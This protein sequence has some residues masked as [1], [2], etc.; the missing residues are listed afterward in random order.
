MEG[1][2]SQPPRFRQPTF[3]GPR[4]GDS[5]FSNRSGSSQNDRFGFNFRPSMPGQGFAS[6]DGKK[7]RTKPMIRRTVDYNSSVTRFIKVNSNLSEAVFMMTQ[8]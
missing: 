6:F 3:G 2:T 8:H 1:A 7:L 4:F 5:P